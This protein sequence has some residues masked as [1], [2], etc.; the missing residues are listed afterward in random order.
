M[1]H[2]LLC[3]YEAMTQV[4]FDLQCPK[5][6]YVGT[7]STFARNFELHGWKC[8]LYEFLTAEHPCNEFLV[9]SW[10]NSKELEKEKI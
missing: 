8:G 9:V 7:F 5:H 1:A 3:V 6:G 10:T 2:D 4:K